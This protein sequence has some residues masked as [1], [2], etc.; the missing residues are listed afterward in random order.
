MTPAEIAAICHEANRAYS[1]ILGDDPQVPW[2]DAP[3][4]MQARIIRGVELVLRH[5]EMTPEALHAAWC[6]DRQADGWV[7]GATK[8]EVAKTHPC[9][10]PYDQLPEGQRRKDR[11]FGAI[12][13]ALGSQP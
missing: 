11:L 1:Q 8:D 12:V 3:R 6:Q 10:V 2:K 7:Y 5:P 13:R 4:W 9:L